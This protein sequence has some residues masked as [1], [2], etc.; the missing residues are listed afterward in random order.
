MTWGWAIGRL[1]RAPPFLPPSPLPASV[2]GVGKRRSIMRDRRYKARVWTEPSRQH[3]GGDGGNRLRP[4]ATKP[5]QQP[6]LPSLQRPTTVTSQYGKKSGKL[7]IFVSIIIDQRRQSRLVMY[8]LLSAQSRPGMQF[9]D[10][11][12]PKFAPVLFVIRSGKKVASPVKYTG[13]LWPTTS[14]R[15][16]K[17]SVASA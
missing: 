2:L 3:W 13:V 15:Y 11:S 8:Q 12:L 14:K 5:I 7:F 9:N 17:P 1:F 4:T 6:P 10:Y 16:A